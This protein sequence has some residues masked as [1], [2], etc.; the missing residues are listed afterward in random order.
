MATL[1]LLLADARFPS[2]GHAHS[3]G[4]EEACARGLVHDEAS[5]TDFLRGR[6]LCTGT[7]FAQMAAFVCTRIGD[8]EDPGWLWPAVDAECDARLASPAARA[9]SRRQGAQLLRSA[10]SVF[11]AG[12]LRSL[13]HPHHPVAMGA[14]AA[15]AGLDA[16]GAAEAAAYGSLAGGAAAAL[17]LLGLDPA[18]TARVVADLAPLTDEVAARAARAGHGPLTRLASA[19]APACDLFAETHFDRK[20]RLFAS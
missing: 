4:V 6:L 18:G 3:G 8:G 14:V 7:V 12:Y 16:L 2:G 15:A 11:D 10:L 17:R 9:V 1:A 13:R 5:L 19:S 20:E